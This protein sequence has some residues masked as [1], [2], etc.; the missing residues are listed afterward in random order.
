VI[1]WQDSGSRTCE[2]TISPN[3][4]RLV[5]TDDDVPSELSLEEMSMSRN[6]TLHAK[7][8][9]TMARWSSRAA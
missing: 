3:V 6:D 4:G 2:N 9:R 7:R 5:V 8:R 1:A